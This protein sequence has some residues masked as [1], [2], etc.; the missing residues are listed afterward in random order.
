MFS[1][2]TIFSG[3]IFRTARSAKEIIKWLGSL[4]PYLLLLL[5]RVRRLVIKSFLLCVLPLSLIRWHTHATLLGFN[6]LLSNTITSFAVVLSFFPAC[7]V[8]MDQHST[9][10]FRTNWRW[11]QGRLWS[12][13]VNYS[14]IISIVWWL[15]PFF[16]SIWGSFLRILIDLSLSDKINPVV[17]FNVSCFNAQLNVLILHLQCNVRLNRKRLLW[18]AQT[19]N[20]L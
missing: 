11:C 7:A 2:Q 13:G 9:A 20:R 6:N 12:C 18:P 1:P 17:S 16:I 10:P 5:Q 3:S 14:I 8:I 15:I 4:L 19:I